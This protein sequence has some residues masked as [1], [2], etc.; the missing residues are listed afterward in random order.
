MWASCPDFSPLVM[1]P[2]ADPR[3]VRRLQRDSRA[4]LL[5]RTVASAYPVG[6]VFKVLAAAAAV[7]EGIAPASANCRGY[8]H[9][10]GRFRCWRR[11][12]HGRVDLHEAIVRSCNIYFYIVGEQLGRLREGEP[13]CRLV[14]WAR[15]FGLGARSGVDLPGERSGLVPS[16]AWKGKYGPRLGLGRGW[17]KADSRFMAVGQGAILVTPLQAARAMAGVVSGGALPHPHVV[18]GQGRAPTRIALR[19]RTVMQ[20]KAA[21]RDVVEST[22]GTGHH[23]ARSAKVSIAGKTGTAETGV[24]IG[25]GPE[26]LNHAW[27]VGYAPTDRPRIV[28][29]VVLERVR[30]HAGEEAGPVARAV[31]EAADRILNL[32]G[33]QGGVGKP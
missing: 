9:A 18:E 6:S 13:E 21:M 33:E 26:T 4:P 1:L 3:A 30:G 8:L 28:V 5:N 16:R 2:G 25:A 17:T 31:F 12:G 10:P 32:G 19:P 7:E 23:Y 22:A 15:Q 20:L 11:S 29:A 24:R 27:F 14:R